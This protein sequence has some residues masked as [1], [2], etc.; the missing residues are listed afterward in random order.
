MKTKRLEVRLT[1][2]L[3]ARVRKLVALR[4]NPDLGRTYTVADFIREA[5]VEKLDREGG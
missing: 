5:A 3:D 2:A 4:H 1:P